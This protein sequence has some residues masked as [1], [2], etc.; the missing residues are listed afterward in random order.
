MTMTVP[1]ND[2]GTPTLGPP[3]P[4]FPVSGHGDA[5]PKS[6]A[7]MEDESQPLF[8]QVVE[9]TPQ[10]P[11]PK[12]P[13][14]ASMENELQ[15]LVAEVVEKTSQ[16]PIPR[17]PSQWSRLVADSWVIELLAGAVSFAAIASIISVLWGYDQKPV[18]P[19]WKGITVCLSLFACTRTLGS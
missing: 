13:E 3:S 4:V 18:P 7:S 17:R 9:K 6:A 14:P 8:A 15:P 16:N 11:I 1:R 5:R 2:S 19:L 12:R 10:S